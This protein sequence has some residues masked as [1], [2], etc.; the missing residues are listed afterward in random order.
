MLRPERSI[1]RVYLRRAPVDMRRQMD[2]LALLARDVMQIDPLSGALFVF[3]NR[4]RNKL[5]CLT[6]ENNGFVIWYKPSQ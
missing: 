4:R 2:G 3:I 1:E 6:W 5:K